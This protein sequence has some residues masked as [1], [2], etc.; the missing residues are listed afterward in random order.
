MGRYKL[1]KTRLAK[2]RNEARAVLDRPRKVFDFAR[3]EREMSETKE[4]TKRL[5]GERHAVGMQTAAMD[6]RIDRLRRQGDERGLVL[7]DLQ[8]ELSEVDMSEDR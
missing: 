6:G 1:E 2:A 7:Q 5:A 4:E 8:G 3:V